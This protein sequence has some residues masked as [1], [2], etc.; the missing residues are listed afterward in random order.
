ME[1]THHFGKESVNVGLLVWDWSTRKQKPTNLLDRG[2]K[3][4][5]GGCRR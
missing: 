1:R 4:E 5:I 3:W 2:I